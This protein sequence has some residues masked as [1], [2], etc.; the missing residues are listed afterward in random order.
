MRLLATATVIVGLLL[1]GCTDERADPAPPPDA[2]EIPEANTIQV[3]D[4]VGRDLVRAVNAI[5]AAGLKVD[6]SALSKTERGYADGNQ[7]HPR[8]QVVVMDPLPGAEVEEALSSQSSRSSVHATSL[9]DR[10]NPRWP[11]DRSTG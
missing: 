2:Q 5:E 10:G 3:L 4:V 7:T 8:V 1:G 9:A 11:G 6:V